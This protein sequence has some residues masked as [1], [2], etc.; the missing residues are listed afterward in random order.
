MTTKTYQTAPQRFVAMRLIAWFARA[1]EDWQLPFCPS[2]NDLSTTGLTGRR[3]NS[4]LAPYGSEDDHVAWEGVDLRVW[5][6]WIEMTLARISGYHGYPYLEIVRCYISL[7]ATCYFV[8][9]YWSIEVASGG[10]IC[11]I[12]SVPSVGDAQRGFAATKG[13]KTKMTME[14]QPFEDIFPIEHRNFPLSC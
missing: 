4:G 8:G 7:L 9:I 2:P 14:N 11:P 5:E 10:G 13:P 3:G 12:S 6:C 1:M